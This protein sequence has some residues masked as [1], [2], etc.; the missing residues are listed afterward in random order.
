LH[1]KDA[2]TTTSYPFYQKFAKLTQ[3]EQDWG[4]LDDLQAISH[5]RSWLKHLNKHCAE[6][7]GHRLVWR[8]DADPYRIKLLRSAIR[9]RQTE[10]HSNNQSS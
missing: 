8:K 1:Y 7:Q 2:C 9:A 3:Q 10:R 5:Q 4:L 6:L